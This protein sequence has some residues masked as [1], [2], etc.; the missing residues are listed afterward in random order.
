MSGLEH[1]TD[2]EARGAALLSEQFKSQPKLVALLKSWLA[3]V[4]ALEDAAYQLQVQRAL[5]TATG[6][7]L[8]VLGAIVGQSRGGRT[9]SQYRIWIAGRVL[10][11]KSRGRPPQLIAIAS[12][13]CE[14]PVEFRE[15]ATAAFIMYSH[16]PVLGTDGVE[17]AKLLKLAKAGGISMQFVWYDTT[18]PFRFSPTGDP[19]FSSARG[20]GAG[21]LAA[22]SDG[23]E[24]AFD[25]PESA[26]D[27]GDDG[28]ALL[29]VL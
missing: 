6:K 3:Q 1:V 24:M 22:V 5:A 4:Q 11:N 25:P 2:H 17:I 9:D 27:E 26:P 13:L 7:N 16:S 23:R 12:K 20:F 10:V 28:G 18:T 19:L 14:G 15:Y 29:V 21:R 8:D